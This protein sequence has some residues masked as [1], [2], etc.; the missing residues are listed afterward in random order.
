[1]PSLYITF[2]SCDRSQTI[3]HQ[4]TSV[5]HRGKG[6]HICIHRDLHNR[7]LVRDRRI[8]CDATK[9]R[10]RLGLH[11]YE[12]SQSVARLQNN[13]LFPSLKHLPES[14]SRHLSWLMEKRMGC[15]GRVRNGGGDA[16]GG[17]LEHVDHLWFVQ[18]A[19]RLWQQ[20]FGIVTTSIDIG[21]ARYGVR[22]ASR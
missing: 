14:I 1:M 15:G 3:L 9:R 21:R 18:L 12:S 20:D 13:N 2:L 10:L 17:T 11:L 6:V 19:I 16:R 22:C 4:Q 8:S 7:R 5:T